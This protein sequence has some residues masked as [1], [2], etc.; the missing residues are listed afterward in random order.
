MI[1]NATNIGQ[2]LTGIGRYPLALSLYFL[3]HWDY[4]FQLFIN[5][6]A[7]VHFA[8]IEK[9]YKIRL[10]EGNISPDFGFRGNL[11]RLL[12][13]NKLGLQNQKELIFNA[14]Q[15]EGCFLHE[16]QIITVHDLIPIIFPRYHK[17]L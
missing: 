17:K 15:M 13:S 4:P 16:K 14:S 11:L 9:K 5:K 10:V 12:W 6:R 3:E 2:R 7:L 1:I 8:K